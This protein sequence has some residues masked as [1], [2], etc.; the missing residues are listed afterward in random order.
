ML[1]IVLRTSGRIIPSNTAGDVN[2][3]SAKLWNIK[4]YKAPDVDD[5]CCARLYTSWLSVQQ[6]CFFAGFPM[7]TTAH[8]Q[9]FQN[10]TVRINCDLSYVII[11]PNLYVRCIDYQSGSSSCSSCAWWCTMST[12]HAALAIYRRFYQR[13]QGCLIADCNVHQPAP[14]T[15]YPPFS[16]RLQSGIFLVCLPFL[17]EQFTK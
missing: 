15:N 17:I 11:W 16:T 3:S 1:S 10:A 9:R 6:S 12:P 13:W 4:S 14:T 5:R 2:C 8:Q 7:S